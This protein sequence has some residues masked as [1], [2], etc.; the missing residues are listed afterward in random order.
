MLHA[1]FLQDETEAPMQYIRSLLF[2]ILFL[3]VTSYYALS[4]W[5]L[6][7]V[8]ISRESMVKRLRRRSK[9]VTRRLLPVAGVRFECRNFVQPIQGPAIICANHESALD[10]V[11]FH[12]LTEDPAYWMKSE[13][14]RIPFFGVCARFVGM[15]EV[16][17]S[18]NIRHLSQTM[19]SSKE[20]LKRWQTIVAFPEG[21]RASLAHPIPY[22]SGIY[23]LYKRA[24]LPIIPV[25]IASGNCW[26]KKA[27]LLKPGTIQV[28]FLEP[29]PPGLSKQELMWRL[30]NV[31]RAEQ[32]RLKAA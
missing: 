15:I 29:I 26:G 25:A 28:S 13:L 20:A 16:D 8:G 23:S 21:T 5:L 4:G 2:H 7:L 14:F 11:I 32:L 30:E 9:I 19:R 27:F 18:G 24:E 3:L 10:T 31:I 6:I 1:F 22:Q 17:R 12:E